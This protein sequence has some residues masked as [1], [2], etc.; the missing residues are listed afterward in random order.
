VP[1]VATD[2]GD[3]AWIIGPS[4][5]VVPPRDL[6]TLASAV[7][8]MLDLDPEQRR[9]LGEAARARTINLFSLHSVAQQYEALYERVPSGR[10][11]SW[12][13]IGAGGAT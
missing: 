2:V 7:V 10:A 8:R 3:S 1:C 12:Q 9:Q 4:D 6:E 11:G 13:A 5:S